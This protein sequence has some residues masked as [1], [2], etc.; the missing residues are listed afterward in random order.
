MQ[1][2]SSLATY[3][4][5]LTLR[6]AK[7]WRKWVKQP[8]IWER[9]F[10]CYTCSFK[11]LFLI[12]EIIVIPYDFVYPL[13]NNIFHVILFHL[14][15]TFPWIT[16]LSA[17][18][19]SFDSLTFP[20]CVCSRSTFPQWITLYIVTLNANG[21]EYDFIFTTFKIIWLDTIWNRHF[22]VLCFSIALYVS[23]NQGIYLFPFSPFS[24]SL[25][26]PLLEHGILS[27]FPP[28][29]LLPSPS[30]FSLLSPA[31][32]IFSRM[33]LAKTLSSNAEEA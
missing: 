10:P 2:V 8:V 26:F 3:S 29:S 27:H 5:Q 7:L 23:L 16:S 32:L 30:P 11:L 18:H 12:I 22:L 21:I 1:N 4:P 25:S 31:L 17:G 9:R 13:R 24:H 20:L 14:Q 33:T 28:S 15:S 19:K 6:F